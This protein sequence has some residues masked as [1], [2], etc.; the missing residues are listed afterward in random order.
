MEFDDFK[1]TWKQQ[2][3]P[4]NLDHTQEQLLMLLNNKVISFEEQIKA[5]DRREIFAAILVTVIFGVFFFVLPSIWQ[6]TGSAIIVF[7]GILIGYKIKTAQRESI[8]QETDP[9]TSL[10]NHL[11][12]EL[13]W[14]RQQKRL[15]KTVIW[16]YVLPL[17]IGIILFAIGFEGLIFKLVYIG[18]VILLGIGVLWLNKY[19]VEKKH[20]PIIEELREALSFI[21]NSKK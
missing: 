15:L 10:R 6:K 14:M 13:Q 9:D 8:K 11:S 18:V 21:E 2:E 16:W 4:E 19:A 5:R 12:H 17:V 20:N 3:T 1:Q 7:S